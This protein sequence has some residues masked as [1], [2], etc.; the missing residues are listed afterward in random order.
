MG[1]CVTMNFKQLK[2]W[3][4]KRWEKTRIKGKFRFVLINGVVIGGFS[5]SIVVLISSGGYR[6][7]V[8]GHISIFNISAALLLFSIF[9]YFCGLGFWKQNESEYLLEEKLKKQR[10]V[11]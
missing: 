2:K 4:L 9:G 8:S 7:P 3:R 11:D 1:V 10:N 5:L 6:D